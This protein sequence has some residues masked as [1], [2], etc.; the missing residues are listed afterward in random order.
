MKIASQNRM[1]TTTTQAAHVQTPLLTIRPST[2]WG[3]INIKELIQYRDLL[4]VLAGRDIKLRYRQTLLGPI[5]IVLQP[6]LGAGVMN[7]IFGSVAKL[8]TP[9][10]M[11]TFLLCF[12]GQLGWT[13]FAG[14]VSKVSGSLVSNSHLVAKVY[15]PR[16]LLPLSS[17][18]AVLVD[19]AAASLIVPFL[20]LNYHITPTASLL[21]LPVWMLL[22]AMLGMGVGLCASALIV[23]YRD[24]SAVLNVVMGFLPYVSGVGFAVASL[25]AKYQ[26]LALYNPV[27]G[28]I[29]A[30]R[31]SLIGKGDFH[32]NQ[33]AY[34]VSAS[35]VMFVVGV[36]AFK[37]MERRFADVI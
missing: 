36:L 24:V 33:V 6:L 25:P 28:L 34:A 4:F 29:E 27:A 32:V 19:F 30:F 8:P 17:V 2:G 12:T 1:N 5:W 20:M 9:G 18:F 37:R 22:L 26:P 21:M 16:L 15:F 7:F 35:L 23:S 14:I 11:P 3:A 31:W 13:I 10:G